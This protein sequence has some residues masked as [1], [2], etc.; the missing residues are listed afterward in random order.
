MCIRDSLR[1]SNGQSPICKTC[2]WDPA[3]PVL[4]QGLRDPGSS[5]GTDS[6]TICSAMLQDEDGDDDGDGDDD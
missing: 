1:A 4:G 3:S 2:S 6:D 5:A